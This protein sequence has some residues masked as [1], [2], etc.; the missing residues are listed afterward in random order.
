MKL[1]ITLVDDTGAHTTHE[2]PITKEDMLAAEELTVKALELTAVLL[3]A[4]NARLREQTP[5]NYETEKMY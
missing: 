1:I 2:I 4:E 3:R 5:S